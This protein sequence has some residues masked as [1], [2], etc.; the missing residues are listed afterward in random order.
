MSECVREKKKQL[1]H[2]AARDKKHFKRDNK[3]KPRVE[4]SRREQ[5]HRD[6]F[7]YFERGMM[8]AIHIINNVKDNK[9]KLNVP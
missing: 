6:N 3:M 1:F 2:L 4:V 5:S 7:L 8:C 9:H